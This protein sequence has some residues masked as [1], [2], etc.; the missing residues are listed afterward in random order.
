MPSSGILWGVVVSNVLIIFFKTVYE[1]IGY[2]YI[3][4]IMKKQMYICKLHQELILCVYS[5]L[6]LEILILSV[7]VIASRQQCWSH[8]LGPTRKLTKM[9]RMF[10]RIKLP[11]RRSGYYISFS[12]SL[13]PTIFRFV[14]HLIIHRRYRELKRHEC[15]MFFYW[16][17]AHISQFTQTFYQQHCYIAFWLILSVVCHRLEYSLI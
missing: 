11:L 7:I 16:D 10:L 9:Y 5:F 12:T 6:L 15:N 17:T 14:Q 4:Q 1:I 8:S 3:H 13:S 2:E